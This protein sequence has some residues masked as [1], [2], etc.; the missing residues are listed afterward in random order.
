MLECLD[1]V[2]HC[3]EPL[4]PIVTLLGFVDWFGFHIVTFNYSKMYPDFCENCGTFLALIPRLG[5]ALSACSKAFSKKPTV[6]DC[7]MY[8]LSLSTSESESLR[9]PQDASDSLSSD[10]YS[11]SEASRRSVVSWVF[12]LSVS[13]HSSFFCSRC[14]HPSSLLPSFWWPSSGYPVHAQLLW[15]LI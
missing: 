13:C 15:P 14:A 2:L 12:M 11:D 8:S 9:L 10:A 5:S 4:V 7:E 3:P 6:S 1:L